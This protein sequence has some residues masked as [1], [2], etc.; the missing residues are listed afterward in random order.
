[1]CPLC[2]ILLLLILIIL[3]TLIYVFYTTK[4]QSHPH[5]P[6]RRPS[7]PTLATGTTTTIT[8]EKISQKMNMITLSRIETDVVE[9][10]MEQSGGGRGG[11]RGGSSECPVCL[12]G[13]VKGEEGLCKQAWSMICAV[14]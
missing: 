2:F 5:D 14:G 4:H 7:M 9:A 11:G 8:M 1:M 13:F 12:S 3:P 10:V 6:P